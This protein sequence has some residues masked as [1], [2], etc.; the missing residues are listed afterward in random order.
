MIYS[1]AQFLRIFVSLL[2]RHPEANV[3]QILFLDPS[4]CSQNENDGKVMDDISFAVSVETCS[5]FHIQAQ[6]CREYP[7]NRPTAHSTDISP[8]FPPSLK[9]NSDPQKNGRGDSKKKT[10][11]YSTSSRGNVPP[12]LQT[13]ASYHIAGNRQQISV[14]WC[15]QLQ[16]LLCTRALLWMGT[17]LTAEKEKFYWDK[18]GS[19][20]TRLVGSANHSLPFVSCSSFPSSS[21]VLFSSL[22][23]HVDLPGIISAPMT[24]SPREDGFFGSFLYS[25]EPINVIEGKRCG[26]SPSLTVV[27]VEGE[28]KDSN[29]SL[30]ANAPCSS[31]LFSDSFPIKIAV[32]LN[33]VLPSS[34]THIVVPGTSLGIA[35]LQA[36]SSHLCTADLSLPPPFPPPNGYEEWAN[37]HTAVCEPLEGKGGV[38]PLV[39]N[40][41]LSCCGYRMRADGGEEGERERSGRSSNVECHPF[42]LSSSFSYDP[43]PTL[44]MSLSMSKDLF[45]F[46]VA[47]IYTYVLPHVGLQCIG[48]KWRN[49]FPSPQRKGEVPACPSHRTYS[50]AAPQRFSSAL[51]AR[52]SSGFHDWFCCGGEDAVE[53]NQMS[54]S[55]LAPL[56]GEHEKEG[57]RSGVHRI[58]TFSVADFC[59]GHQGCS[60]VSTIVVVMDIPLWVWYALYARCAIRVV[61]KSSQSGIPSVASLAVVEDD[62]AEELGRKLAGVITSAV[63]RVA[64]QNMD[65]FAFSRVKQEKANDCGEE[66][67]KENAQLSSTTSRIR[68]AYTNEMLIHSIAEN[69]TKMLFTSSNAKFVS[70]AQRL[71]WGYSECSSTATKDTYETALATAEGRESVAHE[72]AFVHFHGEQQNTPAGITSKPILWPQSF[73]E[74]C[75]TIEERLR[76]KSG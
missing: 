41:P 32:V 43:V 72:G 26:P 40:F 31:P 75:H 4:P 13:L 5:L 11:L 36:S 58:G 53:E 28:E 25:T 12:A 68:C 71:L 49:A 65:M 51:P 33:A 67:E 44:A 6:F 62:E 61:V 34:D 27:K 35:I 70:E 17:S 52:D 8:F 73:A 18:N 21:L 42:S 14:Y 2:E 76:I 15:G 74:V 60:R 64:A 69:I 1:P 23:F 9:S 19:N 46:M 20:D 56:D 50:S 59:K 55:P 24:W 16:R 39:N 10:A 48:A 57:K 29:V 3:V 54:T 45:D 30:I 47:F 7:P 38:V 22:R 66:W 63:A 37:R